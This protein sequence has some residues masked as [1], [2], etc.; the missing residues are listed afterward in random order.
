M[1]VL[2][3][4]NIYEKI[5]SAL[6]KSFQVNIEL[7]QLIKILDIDLEE[8]PFVYKVYNIS[9]DEFIQFTLYIPTLSQYDF[10]EFSFYYECYKQ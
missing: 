5:G 9:E 8:D 3:E 1:D 4:I 2:R 10:E 6:I 7:N